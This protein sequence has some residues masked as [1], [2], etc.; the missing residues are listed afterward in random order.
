MAVG[1]L[2]PWISV[3][4]TIGASSL[5][6]TPLSNTYVSHNVAGIKG[7][8]GKIVLLCG[9]A[10]VIIGIAAMAANGKLGIAAAAPAIIGILVI[11]KVFGDKASYDDKLSSLPSASRTSIDVSF[12]GGI[13]VSLIM[14]IAVIGLGVICAVTS[15]SR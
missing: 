12:M 10:A 15:K 8:E 9:L 11:F 2:L 7:S 1:A 6:E 13:Y 3:K 4:L 14:A 5:S